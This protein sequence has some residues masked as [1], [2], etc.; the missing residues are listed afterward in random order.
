M[1]LLNPKITIPFH[2]VQLNLSFL[3]L[4]K[5]VLPYVHAMLEYYLVKKLWVH[6]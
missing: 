1:S 6:K 2:F 4:G 5:E 3:L